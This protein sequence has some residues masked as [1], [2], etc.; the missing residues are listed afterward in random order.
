VVSPI[1]LSA[2]QPADRFYRGGENIRQFRS[3]SASPAAGHRVP[4]DWVGS[5]TALFGERELGQSV[6]PSGEWLAASIAGNPD[7]WLGEEHVERFGADPMLLVK[8]LDAGQRLPVHI[9]P[10]TAFAAEHLHAPHGKAEAWYILSGGEI[11]LGFLRDVGI[12]ELAGWVASQDVESMLGAMHRIEVNAGDSVY[13]PPGLPHAIGEGVFLVEVQQPADLSILVEWKDFAIDGPAE[14]HLGLGFPLAL[15]AADTTEW[16]EPRIRTLIVRSGMG[17][18]TLPEAAG[19]YFR[20]ERHD[21][22]SALLLDRGFS[23]VIVLDG[24]GEM[25]T[26]AGTLGLTRGDTVLI[27][28]DSGELKLNGTMSIVRCRPPRPN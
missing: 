16:S 27:P 6:L 12:A 18:K 15:S 10:S 9:H 2:N 13:V 17:D 11:H 26:R 21:V 23:V 5:V 3:E 22:S 7:A 8:L 1:H 19:E 4:E 24:S 20:A 28:H 25:T 14:G